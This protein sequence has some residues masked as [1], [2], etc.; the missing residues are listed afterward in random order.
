MLLQSAA[1]VLCS[2][3]LVSSLSGYGFY[4][5]PATSKVPMITGA[6]PTVLVAVCAL[7]GGKRI[8]K[9]ASVLV[10]VGAQMEFGMVWN[11]ADV[12]MGIMA[13]INLPIIVMLGGKAMMAL[14]DYAEQRKAGKDPVY[15]AASNGVQEKTDFWK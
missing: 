15:H 6:L 11:L 2:F 8:V 1:M 14:K 12:L 13:I 10:F 4:G 3:N 7:G 5:D 9:V